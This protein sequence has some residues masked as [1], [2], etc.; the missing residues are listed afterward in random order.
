MT[1]PQIRTLLR[2]PNIQSSS[3]VLLFLHVSDRLLNLN[4]AQ[5]R[6]VRITLPNIP[7]NQHGCF[8]LKLKNILTRLNIRLGQ[9]ISHSHLRQRNQ[10]PLYKW[11]STDPD[12]IFY[13][14]V[15]LSDLTSQYAEEIE[16]CRH[17]LKLPDPRDT[18][19]SPL[20]L[21]WGWTLKKVNRS[22][23]Q[24]ALQLYSP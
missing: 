14:E 11:K 22:L 7:N 8:W 19:L 6:M 24:E 18:M 4:M 20:P 10:S 21:F 15:D 17:I 12:P 2:A 1:S 13:R 3:V 9:S 16:T 5:I 23:G